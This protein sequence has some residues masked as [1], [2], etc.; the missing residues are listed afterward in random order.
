MKKTL[1]LIFLMLSTL[2]F[3]LPLFAFDLGTKNFFD[4]PPAANLVYPA[5]EE[6]LLAGK[7]SLEFQ[8]SDDCPIETEGY[9]FR[10][11]NG[12]GMNDAVLIAKENLPGGT[13]ALKI[14]ADK[15]EDGSTYTWSVKRIANGGRKSDPAYNSFRV[16]K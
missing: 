1:R 10:L 11:Y 13:T 9:E 4:N 12:Y 14:N 16:K 6:A 2:A 8:W 3:I 15:F 5:K 7:G